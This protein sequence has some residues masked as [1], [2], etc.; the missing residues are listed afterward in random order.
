MAAAAAAEFPDS[1]ARRAALRADCRF[2]RV[3]ARAP[4]LRGPGE[5]PDRLRGYGAHRRLDG[6]QRCPE[7]RRRHRQRRLPRRRRRAGRRVH[8][9]QHRQPAAASSSDGRFRSGENQFRMEG[10]EIVKHGDDTYSFE[11]GM[12]TTCRCP[13]GERDPWQIRA[14]SAD[15]EVG[16]Y[17]TARNTT[18]EILGVPVVWL[19]WMIY[20]LKTERQSGLLFPEFGYGSR[21]GVD[22]GLPIFWAARDNLNITADAAVAQQARREGRPRGRVRVRREVGGGGLRIVPLRRGHRPELSAGRPSIASAGWCTA[23]R[24]SSCPTIWR[25]KSD[26]QFISDNEYLVDFDDL[27]ERVNDRFL[28]SN[29]FRGPVVRRGRP[30]RRA[31]GAIVYA[32]DLQNPDDQDRDK[33]LLQRLPT[34]G[35]G[36][37][38]GRRRRVDSGALA[39]HPV[40]RR[41]VHLLR[42]RA[43]RAVDKYDDLDARLLRRRHLHRHGHRRDSEF[44]SERGFRPLMDPDPN[45]DPHGDDAPY[46]IRE[47]RAR[48]GLRG[49]GA[50]GRRRPPHRSSSRA[51]ACRSGSETSSRPIPRWGGTRPSTTPTF[52]AR[53]SGTCSRRGS[54]CAAA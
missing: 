47:A 41:R 35:A 14:G 30:L 37:A 20:P 52:R 40:L 43:R 44:S 53:R 49:R 8:R 46:A 12:F 5:R 39:D 22:I 31:G 1:S 15:L 2:G 48:R 16:G 50:A 33:F 24:T 9:V 6:V 7:S 42:S 10:D 23:S 32:D 4:H 3:R 28:Q 19:P 36:R 21:N 27:P 17:G 54:T 25:L 18:F 13:P 26:F 38:A 51:W 45:P 34:S 11:E 29:A